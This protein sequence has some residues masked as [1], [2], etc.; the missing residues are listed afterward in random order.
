MLGKPLASRL[1][2]EGNNT[3]LMVSRGVS[4][5]EDYVK[6]LEHHWLTKVWNG[7]NFILKS[8]QSQED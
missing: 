6:H 7:P 3:H 5:E 2:S 8:K 4:S 1:Q